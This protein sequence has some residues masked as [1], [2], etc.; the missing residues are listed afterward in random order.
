MHCMVGNTISRRRAGASARARRGRI[1]THALLCLA[2][3]ASCA[4]SAQAISE[5]LRGVEI[6]SDLPPVEDKR[7]GK[8]RFLDPGDGQF[9]L[10]YFL[11]N[12]KGFLPIP[13]LIRGTNEEGAKVAIA[14]SFQNH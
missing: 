6:V 1:A 3:G 14:F 2:I 7:Q 11:E 9:D 12:P 8:A 5:P 4:A 13:K 10:S